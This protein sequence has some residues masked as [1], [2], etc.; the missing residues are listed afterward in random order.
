MVTATWHSIAD[1]KFGSLAKSYVVAGAGLWPA[2][3]H[4]P[5]EPANGG[6]SMQLGEMK[7]Q[8]LIR[9]YVGRLENAIAVAKELKANPANS[10]YSRQSWPDPHQAGKTGG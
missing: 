1:R 5:E 8:E 9:E 3:D 6:S 7:D 10:K 4:F 2:K